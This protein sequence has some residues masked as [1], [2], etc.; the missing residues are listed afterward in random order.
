M[1]IFFEFI[2]AGAMRYWLI[3][4]DY[5]Q[6]ISNRVELTTPLN[7]WRRLVEGIYLYS[8]G[9]DPYQGDMFHESPLML[10]LF[11]R[12]TKSF[13]LIIPLIFTLCDMLTA[14]LLYLTTKKFM[15]IISENQERD[16]GQ[17]AKDSLS[18]LLE[19]SDF[20]TA[21]VYVLT[22]YLFN[23]YSILNCVAMTT[24][25]FNNMFVSL[26]LQSM[27]NGRR[28]LSCF[29]IAVAAHQTLY[30]CF[31][32]VPAAIFIE[33]SLKGCAKCSYI[34]TL[35]V[36]VLMWGALIYLSAFAMNGSYLFLEN[37]YGFM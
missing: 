19:E 16:S 6:G 11:H 12:I 25:V 9:I 29:A 33:N 28:T 30:P 3:T 21:P 10:L 31:L 20:K 17:Y 2:F 32:I 24:T 23:P 8:E 15:K 13:P 34:K 18:L 26:A 14:Y 4:S 27:I 35:T 22:V 1:F 5:Q 36:F 7:S 37:T